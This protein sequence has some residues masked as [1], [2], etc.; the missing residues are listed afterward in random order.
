MKRYLAMTALALASSVLPFQ[1]AQAETRFSMV[2]S[3]APPA[4]RFE[5][6]PAPRHG[7]VWAPGYWSWN[8]RHHVWAA[9]HW[10]PERA[11][12]QYVYSEWVPSQGGWSLREGGW[13]PVVDVVVAPPEPRYEAVPYPRPGYVW[14]PGYWEWRGHRHE[15][16][17]GYWIAERPG[18]V[19][20]PNTWVQNRGHWEM[21]S[22]RWERRHDRDGDG[23]PN[24]YD[25]RPNDPYRH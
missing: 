12:Y 23:V 13:E 24:R 3:N 1:P 11:G 25:R 19:Y 10:I 8:G 7:Y 5:S 21:Q 17:Q 22:G 14:A 15:W 2:V 6:V 20:V 18:H 4:P 9:G 16:V